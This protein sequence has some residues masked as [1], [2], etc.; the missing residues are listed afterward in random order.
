MRKSRKADFEKLAVWGL[1]A[2]VLYRMYRENT[3]LVGQTND[4]GNFKNITKE[5]DYVQIRNIV[6]NEMGKD[7]F[8]A[9]NLIAID[10]RY[11][12]Q[13]WQADGNGKNG[14]I[15]CDGFVALAM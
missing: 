10:A 9:A 13:S 11:A 7:I 14:G 12:N 5:T 1:G 3:P 15:S 2:F 4:T 8:N 6:L